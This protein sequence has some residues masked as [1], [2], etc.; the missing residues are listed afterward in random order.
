MINNFREEHAIKKIAL[1]VTA[2]AVSLSIGVRALADT[3]T[4]TFADKTGKSIEV[5][6]GIENIVSGNAKETLAQVIEMQTK[7]KKL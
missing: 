5:L 1:L 4:A 3:N 7:R 2:L 6:K